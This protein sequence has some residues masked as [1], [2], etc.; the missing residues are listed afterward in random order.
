MR[1]LV[2]HMQRNHSRKRYVIRGFKNNKETRIA[3][4]E[5]GSRTV[6]E[7]AARELSRKQTI[8]DLLAIT[9]ALG[10][11]LSKTMWETLYIFI[12]L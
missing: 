12:N 11:I 1:D 7:D 5:R 10:F 6:V 2:L 4:V 3:G 9:K 8:R